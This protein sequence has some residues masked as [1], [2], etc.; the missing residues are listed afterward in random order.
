MIM[1]MATIATADEAPAAAADG[2]PPA[3]PPPDDVELERVEQAQ[4]LDFFCNET[5][6]DKKTVQQQLMRMWLDNS[7]AAMLQEIEEDADA[8]VAGAN[9]AASA[10]TQAIAEVVTGA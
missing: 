4:M 9:V 8:D 1:L 2:A 5:Q 7:N 6:F 10:I 3:S